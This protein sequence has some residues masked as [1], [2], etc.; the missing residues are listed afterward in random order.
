[1]GYCI[2]CNAITACIG[3][4]AVIGP[5]FFSIAG[6]PLPPSG[7]IF[8]IW[9][10]DHAAHKAVFSVLNDALRTFTHWIDMAAIIIILFKSHEFP[11]TC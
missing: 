1:M 5:R 8:T 2:V 9:T 10:A 7:E 6:I 4:H 11:T 3:H